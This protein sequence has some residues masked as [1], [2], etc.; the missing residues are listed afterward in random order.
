MPPELRLAYVVVLSAIVFGCAVLFSR[1]VVGGDWVE[2][3]LDALLI[4]FAVQYVSVCVP[5]VI[6]LLGVGSIAVTAVLLCGVLGAVA[7][8]R[9]L[10]PP[11]E[12]RDAQW[13]AVVVT[14]FVL[15]YLVSILWHQRRLAPIVND[16]LTYHLPAAVQWLQTGRLGLYEAWY[17]NP[18][19]TY[20]PLAGSALIAWWLAPMHNDVLARFVQVPALLL[21]FFAMIQIVR[22][23]GV[24]TTVAALIAGGAV[25]S[26]PLIS[27]TILTKDDLYLAAFFASAVAGLTRAKLTDP[28]GPWRVGVAVGLML[29]TKYTALLSVPLLLLAVDAPARAGWRARHWLAAV[30]CVVA[31]ASPWYVRNAIL[32]GNP[33]FPVDQLGLPGLFS[34]ER[35]PELASVRGLWKTLVTGYAA[36][37]VPVAVVLA[38]A[39]LAAE[40]ALKSAPV[41]GRPLVRMCLAGPFVGIGL[42]ILTSPYPEVRFVYPS[43]LLLFACGGIVAFALRGRRGAGVV[44]G[45]VMMAAGVATGF[46][47]HLLLMLLPMA[48]VITAVV[49]AAAWGASR[50]DRE[51][52]SRVVAS[53]SIVAVATLGCLV[54]IYFDGFLYA[55]VGY[56]NFTIST[57]RGGGYT[58]LADA[59]EF[60]RDQTPPDA[61][62][63]YAN[64]FYT[65]PLYGFAPTR[66]VVY[67]PT[68][69]A[70]TRLRDLPPATEPLSGE[71]VVPYV[72]AA[73]T[74]QPD[75]AA[76][77]DRLARAEATVLF[78]AKPG[79]GAG[80]TV[81]EL[82]FARQD[83]QRFTP[84]FEDQAAVI[85]RV[86]SVNP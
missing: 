43:L 81:P 42:F 58:D 25:A 86:K 8:R 77:L 33:L 76:W 61:T 11:P 20:S 22:A 55:P 19:N 1:R 45:A 2:T 24:S 39:W 78:I 41:H 44:I 16:A 5:G 73:M 35:S 84:A 18:A 32:T 53:G 75:R 15:A 31:L 14:V 27:Q 70:I 72:T 23:L 4:T 71:Q 26:R 3:L 69:N 40:V 74:A 60:V 36:T 67:V 28:L 66:R 52:R 63:A 37:E 13:P 48:S 30:L 65:Y 50:L 38:I 6:G 10:R 54:Y 68:R 57:W 62:V 17:Y 64:T 47:P 59:W 21:V 85:F 34:T 51:R 12:G 9:Q 7:G 82:D 83:P 49:L 56:K 80:T 46:R 79:H 29:A